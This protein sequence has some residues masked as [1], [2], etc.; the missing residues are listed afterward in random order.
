MFNYDWWQSPV[1]QRQI[2]QARLRCL[3]RRFPEVDAL[4][5]PPDSEE[6]QFL[7]ELEAHTIVYLRDG[8]SYEI[9]DVIEDDG[10]AALV[11][12]VVPMDEAWKVGAFVAVVPFD[13]IVRVEVFAIHPS[14][15]PQESPHITGFRTSS[16]GPGRE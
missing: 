2:E 7:A 1:R 15:K 3:K 9:G 10:T 16:E 12:E 6:G 8:F 11:C 14:E 5:V 4:D 13:D